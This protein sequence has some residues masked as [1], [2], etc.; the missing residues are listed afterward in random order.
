MKA[1]SCRLLSFHS[2]CKNWSDLSESPIFFG[3]S[4]F[5]LIILELNLSLWN[6]IHPFLRALPHINPLR[7]CAEVQLKPVPSCYYCP[8]SVPIFCSCQRLPYSLSSD[9]AQPCFSFPCGT[10]NQPH[11]IIIS[12][13]EQAKSTWLSVVFL[14]TTKNELSC[15]LLSMFP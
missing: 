1:D 7:C 9:V 8:G 5:L 13:F 11:F 14:L 6:L 2:P 15:N 4:V 3:T 10:T 12:F